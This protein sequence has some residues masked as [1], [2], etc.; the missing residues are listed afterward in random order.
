MLRTLRGDPRVCFSCE[1]CGRRRDL[2]HVTLEF[3][4]ALWRRS[5]RL[6]DIADVME[7]KSE[8]VFGN[9]ERVHVR[10]HSS[11]MPQKALLKL[12]P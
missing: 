6:G 8:V 2:A 12:K 10:F 7:E 9:G 11:P 1:N 4:V 3:P 5:S